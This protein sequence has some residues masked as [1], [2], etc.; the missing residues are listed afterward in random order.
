MTAFFVCARGED[1]LRID[2]WGSG[3]PE[4]IIAV[5]SGYTVQKNKGPDFNVHYIR[6]KNPD[7]PSMGIYIG[8][9]PNLFSSQKK[10]IE[11]VKERDVILGKNVEWTIWQEK[12]DGKTTY[13]CETMVREVFK[14]MGGSGVAGLVVHAFIRGPDQKKVNSLKNSLKS[15]RIVRTGEKSMNTNRVIFSAEETKRI[16]YDCGGA[17]PFW[18]PTDDQVQEL[19][20][21]LPKYLKSY[22]PIDDEAVGNCFEYGHQYFGVTKNGRR[23]IYLNAFCKPSRFDPRW[24]KEMIVVRDGG[25]CYFQVYFDPAEKEFINLRY[26]G[27][28]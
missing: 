20:S 15:L 4:L 10:G 12:D 11:T 18:T 5:P 21:L 8:H 6:M 28:A 2:S 7:D 22:P 13:H 24:Q 25:S 17:P 14:G 9:H 16:G 19:E 23:L 26:N 3:A 27:Q 1:V